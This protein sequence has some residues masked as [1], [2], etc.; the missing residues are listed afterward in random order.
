MLRL[1][2]LDW[3][4]ALLAI[5]IMIYHY[6]I[7][8]QHSPGADTLLGRLGIY[9]VSM[10]FVLSGLSM[11]FV[12]CNFIRDGRSSWMFL[13]RRVFRIWP[14]LW[15]AVAGATAGGVVLKHTDIPWMKVFL[16]LTTL[17]GFVSPGSSL[18]TG[19]WS[20]G[21]EMVYYALT[22]G[23]I[24]IFNKRLLYGNLLLLTSAAIAVYFSFYVISEAATLESQWLS[25]INPFNNLVFYCSGMAIYFNPSVHGF[26]GKTSAILFAASLIVL[27]FYPTSAEMVSIVCGPNRIVFYVASML[28]VLAF[29]NLSLRS[30]K[31]LKSKWLTWSLGTLGLGAYGL[32]LL[33]P[34]VYSAF[35]I[36]FERSNVGTAPVLR[37]GLSVV[38]TI[39]ASLVSYRVIEVPLIRWGKYLTTPKVVAPDLCDS[40]P[41]ANDANN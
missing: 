13:V 2:P 23:L 1:E 4:R 11:G 25:Y 17:F 9:A 38:C 29:Y 15:F 14:L 30:P 20:I 5:S 39:I 26:S 22:P 10:F 6:A 35:K 24:M 3:Q 36:L 34:I 16:N 31:W 32:Y 12:Y 40:S 19:G 18:I 8:S 33:H 41:P 7:I 21:N 37:V 27:C 28:M